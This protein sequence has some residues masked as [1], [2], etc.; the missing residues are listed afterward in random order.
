MNEELTIFS[1]PS[2]TSCSRQMK[3]NNGNIK[4]YA[5][6]APASQNGP[7]SHHISA[8]PHHEAAWRKL[9]GSD[10]SA[11][12]PLIYILHKQGHNDREDIHSPCTSE[13]LIAGA[14]ND[15]FR[16]QHSSGGKKKVYHD[17]E[18]D[19]YLGFLGIA[20]VTSVLH[21]G[22]SPWHKGHAALTSSHLKYVPVKQVN[23]KA[24]IV[25]KLTASSAGSSNK[26]AQLPSNTPPYHTTTWEC[27]YDCA[28]NHTVL[29]TLYTKGRKIQWNT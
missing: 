26:K 12:S 9:L 14:W 5:C 25:A 11:L 10:S 29:I 28:Q 3:W 16:E 6:D 8:L 23:M 4:V 17:L 19:Y 15:S 22:T 18:R 21:K 27:F 2:R 13:Y 24:V 7:S 20:S 1:L